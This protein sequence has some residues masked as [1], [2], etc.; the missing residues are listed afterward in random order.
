MEKNVERI[1]MK[2]ARLSYL[3]SCRGLELEADP[4]RRD[5]LL[6]RW[7]KDMVGKKEK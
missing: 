2:K 1:R 7:G 5:G 6:Q 4:P 3:D